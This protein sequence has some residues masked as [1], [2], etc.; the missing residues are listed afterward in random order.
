ML[1]N[2]GTVTNETRVK[3]FDLKS[4]LFFNFILLHTVMTT[5]HS[6]CLCKIT[7]LDIKG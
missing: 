1:G 4:V 7:L 6:T 3:E 2:Q 5:L